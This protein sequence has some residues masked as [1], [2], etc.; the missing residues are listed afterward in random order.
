VLRGE[1]GG[2]VSVEAVG[3]M[4]KGNYYGVH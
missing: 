4:G 3:M 2:K 1:G